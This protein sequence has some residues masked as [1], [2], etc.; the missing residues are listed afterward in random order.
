MA[1]SCPCNVVAQDAGQSC[2]GHEVFLHTMSA[3]AT[4]VSLV[5]MRRGKVRLLATPSR[6]QHVR[7]H[8]L[9]GLLSLEG[10]L[11][12]SCWSLGIVQH[13]SS[14]DQLFLR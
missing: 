10:R 2:P 11:P 14:T 12:A 5:A 1:A 7:C 9:A 6:L 8:V 4:K 13:C 3:P